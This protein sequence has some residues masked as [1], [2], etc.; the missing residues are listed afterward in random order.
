[1]D[2]LC[3]L[4]HIVPFFLLVHISLGGLCLRSGSNEVLGW[5]LRL[6][7]QAKV[8]GGLAM[9]NRE[10]RY[11]EEP[12]SGSFCPGHIESSKCSITALITLPG[13]WK[14]RRAF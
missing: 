2:W 4:S 12:D 8:R 6:A 1:M 14:K 11:G 9:G 10:R 3:S 13:S 7:R 5:I